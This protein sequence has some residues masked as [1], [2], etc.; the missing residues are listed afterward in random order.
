MAY[1][2][3]SRANTSSIANKSRLWLP[4]KLS[5]G[6]GCRALELRP[7]SSRTAACGYG[8]ILLARRN[9]RLIAE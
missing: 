2:I 4:D 6:A 1:A 7:R 3:S 8:Y 9:P 5:R